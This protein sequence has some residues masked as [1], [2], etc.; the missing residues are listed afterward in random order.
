MTPESPRDRLARFVAEAL[1]EHPG[2]RT[3][4]GIAPQSWDKLL[5]PHL[6]LPRSDAIARIEE[7]V[8]WA[9]GDVSKILADDE[10]DPHSRSPGV[11]E[12]GRVL[13]DITELRT[14]FAARF[15]QLTQDLQ[16]AIERGSS[17]R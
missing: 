1:R 14:E 11:G 15:D 4:P 9:P 2:A 5:N 12:L 17:R 13:D 10:F 6:P 3:G 7:R 16:A 8:G